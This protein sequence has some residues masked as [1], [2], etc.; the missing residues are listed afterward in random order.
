MTSIYKLDNRTPKDV[1]MYICNFLEISEKMETQCLT[2]FND[3]YII[4]G[5]T[6]HHKQKKLLGMD[7][8]IVIKINPIGNDFF[9]IDIGEGKW[10]DKGVALAAAWFLFAP[11][12]I[13]SGIGIYKQKTLPTKILNEVSKAFAPECKVG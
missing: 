1:A 2:S 8:A 11:L 12:V 7:K 9:S 13:T 10:A 6:T 5:R 3:E 4:Q